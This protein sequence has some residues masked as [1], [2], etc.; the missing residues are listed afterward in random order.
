[1]DRAVNEHQG[2]WA[3][4]LAKLLAQDLDTEKA[5]RTMGQ[6]IKEQVQQAILDTNEPPL[7]PATIA[8]K[9]FEKPLVW[10]SIMIDSVDY[11]VEK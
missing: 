11:A 5:L 3:G 7:K 1:M 8:R 4:D 2:E 6:R 10:H 9:G